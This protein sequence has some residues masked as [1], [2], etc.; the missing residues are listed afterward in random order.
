[1]VDWESA[2]IAPGEIDLAALTEGRHWPSE[3]VQECRRAY[4][5]SRWPEGSPCSFQRTLDMAQM[6]LHFRWLGER[7]DLAVSEKNL[8]RYD[9]LCLLA[10]RLNLL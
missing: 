2:A 9:H 6:Y 5:S 10:E 3:I 1:M 4:V 7:P 8:A